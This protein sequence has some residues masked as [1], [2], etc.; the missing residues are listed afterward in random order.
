MQESVMR[1]KI[2]RYTSTLRYASDKKATEKLLDTFLCQWIDY[3]SDV[4]TAIRETV[5]GVS[6]SKSTAITRLKTFVG[7]LERDTGEQFNVQWP[8]VDVGNDFERMIYM[9]R[10]LQEVP[11]RLDSIV[12]YLSDRLWT[13]TRTIEDDLAKLRY[14]DRAAD[15]T[16]MQEC[17]T[18]NGMDRSRGAVKFIST[19]HPLLLIENLTSLTLMLQAILEKADDPEHH[20]WLMVTAGHI[21]R[22]LTDYAR[23]RATE[24]TVA[25]YGEDSP[26]VAKIEELNSGRYDCGFMTEDD[27]ESDAAEQFFFCTKAGKP[28]R[29]R[30]HGGIGWTHISIPRF[31]RE[32]PKSAFMIDSNGCEVLVPF[33][34]VSHCEVQN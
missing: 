7:W 29:V 12:D 24:V 30:Y 2:K 10:A 25:R 22:Q 23:R 16:L 28:C 15:A 6:T 27:I 20:E 3:G 26:I 18:I 34:K 1:E 11:E 32:D 19:A 14:R 5:K 21:W 4:A 8:P 31:N 33:S 13:S 17:L 9:M